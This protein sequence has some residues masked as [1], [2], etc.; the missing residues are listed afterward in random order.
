LEQLLGER[1][2][3]PC[4]CGFVSNTNHAR[5]TA[6]WITI[7]LLK[8]SLDEGMAMDGLHPANTGGYSNVILKQ[9]TYKILQNHILYP[10]I[11]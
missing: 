5:F 3:C 7:T 8:L 1:N 6:G 11:V 10:H 4:S 9:K 2:D